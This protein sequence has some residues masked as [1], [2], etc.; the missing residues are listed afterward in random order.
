M[1]YS[2]FVINMSHI[3]IKIVVFGLEI[4]IKYGT[5]EQTNL[6]QNN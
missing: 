2:C 4:I 6:D 1:N 3:F 5:T